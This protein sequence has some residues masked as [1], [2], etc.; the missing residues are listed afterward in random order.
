MNQERLVNDLNAAI[1]KACVDNGFSFGG[2]N[3]YADG[4]SLRVRFTATDSDCS[5]P[6][7]ESGLERIG[8]PKE[9]AVL[10]FKNINDNQNYKISRINYDNDLLP[11]VIEDIATNDEYLVSVVDFLEMLKETT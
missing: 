11:L 9:Y 2:L 4:S 1:V 10:S 3:I 5:Q 8:L 6:S 7:L